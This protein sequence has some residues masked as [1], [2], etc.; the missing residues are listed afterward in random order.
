MNPAKVADDDKQEELDAEKRSRTPSDVDSEVVGAGITPN[1][2]TQ[3]DEI[4]VGV[5]LRTW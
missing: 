2:S 1:L 4:E 3:T 5:G